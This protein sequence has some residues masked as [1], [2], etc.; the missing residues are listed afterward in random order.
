MLAVFV[1]MAAII[2][3]MANKSS[4]TIVLNDLCRVHEGQDVK[5]NIKELL[6]LTTALLKC[7]YYPHGLIAASPE[8]FMS[9]YKRRKNVIF[10]HSSSLVNIKANMKT[11]NLKD[12]SARERSGETVREGRPC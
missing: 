6:L 2:V 4:P 8:R 9:I 1:L 7:Y 5:T 3:H 10:R 11:Y 12:I